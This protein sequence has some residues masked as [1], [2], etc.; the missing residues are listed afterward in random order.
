MH[1]IGKDL[2]RQLFREQPQSPVPRQR[3]ASSLAK[4]GRSPDQRL[5][6]LDQMISAKI[7]LKIALK[8]ADLLDCACLCRAHGIAG[9]LFCAPGQLLQPHNGAQRQ[10]ISCSSCPATRR[11]CFWGSTAIHSRRAAA[12]S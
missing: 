3:P 5:D 8:E 12:R 6:I 11:A 9:K 4:I 10:R 1:A 2:L 7:G